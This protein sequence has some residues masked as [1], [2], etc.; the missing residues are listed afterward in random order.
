MSKKETLIDVNGLVIKT[1]SIYK[2]TNKLDNNAPSGFVKEGTTKLPSSGIGNT[3]PCP[4]KVTNKA[5]GTG[6]FDT[7]LYEGSPCYATLDNETVRKQV[8]K[9]REA[10]VK[11]Y[12]KKYGKGIL[13]HQ[14]EEFWSEFGINLFDGRYFVTN[15]V[16]DLLELYIAMLGYELTPKGEKHEGNPKYSQ[17]DYCIEDKEKVQNIKDERAN[18]MVSAI[19]NFGALLKSDRNTLLNVL[20]YVGLIGVEG[21]IDDATLNSLFFEW[22]NKSNENPKSFDKA[23]ELTK[24]EETFD[25]VNLYAIAS[26]LAI[27]NV[28]TRVG[29]EYT[30]KGKTL[31]ADLKTVSMNLNNKKDLEEIKIELLETE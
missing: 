25:I 13:D 5:K 28:I 15:N 14:N 11:P 9:L 21:K 4:F 12:E 31:G 6:I 29:G 30:Y 23:Y 20:R 16:D 1:D 3:V 17:S 10:I 7:G 19:T 2:V 27:K 24:R 26:R 18:K 8:E 22:L